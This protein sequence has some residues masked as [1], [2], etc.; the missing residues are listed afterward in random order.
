MKYHLLG[1]FGAPLGLLPTH[2]MQHSAAAVKNLA[3]PARCSGH[4]FLLSGT[5]NMACNTIMTVDTM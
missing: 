2:N 3:G 5:Y 4:A 1:L